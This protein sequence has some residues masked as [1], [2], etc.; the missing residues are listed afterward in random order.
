M[1][2]YWCTHSLESWEV[3]IKDKMSV[4]TFTQFPLERVSASKYIQVDDKV[5]MFK[6]DH[7]RRLQTLKLQDFNGDVFPGGETKEPKR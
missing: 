6:G 4:Y 1:S 2:V 5:S 7:S 3:Q